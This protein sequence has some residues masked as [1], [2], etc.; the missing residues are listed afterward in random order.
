MIDQCTNKP[1]VVSTDGDTG[2]YIMVPV[3]QVDDVC[4]LLDA[5]DIRYWV[6]DDAISLDG[7][8]EVTVVNLGS[9]S[10][11]SAIQKILDDA[12]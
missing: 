6:D 12:S 5:N 3:N 2:P 7:K 4:R 11:A 9:G 1:L 10:D 8:P